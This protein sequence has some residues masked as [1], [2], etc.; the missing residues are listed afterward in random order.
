LGFSSLFAST[1]G[2][3][4]TK[5]VFEYGIDKIRFLS[6][7]A[8][9]YANVLKYVE[10]HGKAP[11]NLQETGYQQ[12]K[13]TPVFYQKV[14]DSEWYCKSVNHLDVTKPVQRDEL[15]NNHAYWYFKE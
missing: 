11:E 6:C 12:I 1:Y 7:S 5:E 10:D 8:Q 4:C 14:S 3:L 13:A 9:A 15:L 2:R